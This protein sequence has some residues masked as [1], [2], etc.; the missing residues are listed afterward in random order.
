MPSERLRPGVV[1]RIAARDLLS[2][3]R[4]RRTLNATILMPMILI[5]LFTLGLPLMLGSF[6]GGQQ[7]ARQKLGVVGTLPAA[8]ETALTRDERLA[9]G[10]LIRAG[11]TLVPVENARAAVQ[12]GAVD[13]AV[14]PAGVIPTSAGAAQGTL[15]VYAKLNNL[16]AQA[17]AFAKVQDVVNAYNRTLTLDRLKALGLGAG[18]LTPVVLRPVDASPPQEQRSGQL[19]FLIPMLMLQFILSGAMATAVDATA[20]EKER[21]TLESL[22]VAPV[23]RSEVVAGKLLA[24]TI[25]ALTSACFSVLGFI[26]SGLLV[27][28]FTRGRSGASAEISQAMGGQITLGVGSALALLGVA[29]SAA[30]LISA[31]L[32]TVGIYARSFKEAQT[33]IAPLSLAIVIPAVMLQFSDFLTLGP[34]LY[35]LPLFGG[36]L[37]LL[38]IVRGTVTAAHVLLAMAANL[39]GTVLLGLLALRSFG[40]EEV[41]F[42]N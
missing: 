12:S 2:T 8:L 27:G 23:R 39:V 41:I 31:L 33:Y 16:R 10:T 13:A 21:G 5:P 30:L 24:T 29:L 34:G 15:E 6:I 38:E 19:A 3:L 18:V 7:Q 1:W 11:V 42:R 28:A 37:T 26:L 22:L 35:A 14:Q 9:N 17:G 4:D 20:G 40:R 25:T 32:I 36:M